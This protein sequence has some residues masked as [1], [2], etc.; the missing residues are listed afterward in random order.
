MKQR[1]L[2]KRT[3]EYL[4]DEKVLVLPDKYSKECLIL[5]PPLSFSGHDIDSLIDVLDDFFKN[6]IRLPSKKLR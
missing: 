5:A 6:G 1:I 4:Y 3:Y 2:A